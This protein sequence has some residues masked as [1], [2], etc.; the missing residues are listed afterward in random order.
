MPQQHEARKG[1]ASE[2]AAAEG[3][4]SPASAYDKALARPGSRFKLALGSARGFVIG[5]ASE[6]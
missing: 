3:T 2:T 6:D 4:A 5:G 1:P